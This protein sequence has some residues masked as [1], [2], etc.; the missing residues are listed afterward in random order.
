MYQKDHQLLQTPG[1]GPVFSRI[2]VYYF[3]NFDGGNF[4]NY[5]DVINSALTIYPEIK[6]AVILISRLSDR[7]KAR[8]IQ[9]KGNIFT[10]SVRELKQI[11]MM[12]YPK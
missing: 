11:L 6:K 12:E 5:F 1:I 3:E 9:I 8:L 10:M 2:P 4:K 7:V